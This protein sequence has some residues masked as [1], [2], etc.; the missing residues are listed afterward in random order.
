MVHVLTIIVDGL[1]LVVVVSPGLLELRFVAVNRVLPGMI[2]AGRSCRVPR[3]AGRSC[4]C[5]GVFA[6]GMMTARVPTTTAAKVPAT[7]VPAAATKVPTAAA[8]RVP[9]A[10]TT[11]VPAA[12]AAAMTAVSFYRG[13]R[14]RQSAA[15]GHCAEKFPHDAAPYA[16]QM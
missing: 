15:D 3:H 5:A 1:P 7:R 11:E 12:T 6:A 14:D 10:A 16:F 13:C 9:A 4:S 8:T 2:S